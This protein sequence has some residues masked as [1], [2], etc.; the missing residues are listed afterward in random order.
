MVFFNT[1]PTLSENGHFQWAVELGRG[2]GRPRRSCCWLGS[3]GADSSKQTTLFAPRSSHR[4]QSCCRD[5]V[6]TADGSAPER[7]PGDFGWKSCAGSLRRARN[8]FLGLPAARLEISSERRIHHAQIVQQP[9]GQH[10]QQAASV[11]P[12]Q[13]R[14]DGLPRTELPPPNFSLSG[15]QGETES[16]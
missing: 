7:C 4:L 2:Q 8:P 10:E 6:G 5:R 12:H 11:P 1:E 13:S 16:T 9:P 14:D 3:T 15:S